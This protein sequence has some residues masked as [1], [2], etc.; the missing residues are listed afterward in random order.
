MFVEAAGSQ[1]KSGAVWSNMAVLFRVCSCLCFWRLVAGPSL[2][3]SGPCSN[4]A[5][6]LLWCVDG[7]SETDPSTEEYLG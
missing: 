7:S 3:S 1:P 5:P 6:F 4:F 2:S